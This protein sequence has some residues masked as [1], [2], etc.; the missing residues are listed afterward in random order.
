MLPCSVCEVGDSSGLEERVV[1]DFD[2]DL[3]DAEAEA[4]FAGVLEE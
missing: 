1:F 3:A 4:G 2:A